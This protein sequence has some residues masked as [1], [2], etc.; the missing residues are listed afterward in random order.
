MI[1]RRYEII[2]DYF[3]IAKKVEELKDNY[4]TQMNYTTDTKLETSAPELDPIP[5]GVLEAIAGQAFEYQF[6]I[7]KDAD[8]DNVYVG[9]DSSDADFVE[10]GSDLILEIAEGTSRTGVYGIDIILT[11]DNATEQRNTKY[12]VLLIIFASESASKSTD[13]TNT[14][15]DDLDGI[16]YEEYIKDLGEVLGEDQNELKDYEDYNEEDYEK[17][18]DYI[19]FDDVDLDFGYV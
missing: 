8:G 9:V 10:M 13:L 19:N 17:L 11:D 1:K 3:A 12:W 15:L 6:G 5:P 7:T 14:N 16:E 18:K 2:V 4:F